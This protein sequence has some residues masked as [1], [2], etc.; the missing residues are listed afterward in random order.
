MLARR[1]SDLWRALGFPEYAWWDK[2]WD[3]IASDT[4]GSYYTYL[5][6]E[7]F[8]FDPVEW[9]IE[10]EAEMKEYEAMQET[11]RIFREGLSPFI[12]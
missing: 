12:M 3:D 10:W 8:D 2:Q 5:W 7:K 9:T 11:E 4:F 1:Q 6:L